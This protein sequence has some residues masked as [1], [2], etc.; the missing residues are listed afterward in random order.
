MLKFCFS[1]ELW[2][3]EVQRLAQGLSVS[4]CLSLPLCHG[5]GQVLQ[6]SALP[7]AA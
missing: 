3:Q 6:A 5:Q 4:T 7:S 1:D 2:F